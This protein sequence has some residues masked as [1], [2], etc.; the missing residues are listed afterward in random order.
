MLRATIP[1]GSWA[2]FA[3][4]TF[5][6]TETLSVTAGVRYTEDEKDFSRLV[7]VNDFGMHFAFTPTFVDADGNYDPEGTVIGVVKQGDK[8]DETT[9]RLVVD[10]AVTDDI[11]LYASWAEGYKAGGFNSASDRNNDP[12]FDPANVENLEFGIKS[13]WLDNTLR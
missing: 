10:W 4:F 12:A 13:T 9:P 2:V 6:V 7:L 11:L 1:P 8:W 5:D 3:D